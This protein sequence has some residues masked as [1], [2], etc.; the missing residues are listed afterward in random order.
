MW[1][2]AP[3]PSPS[4]IPGNCSRGCHEY[5]PSK[6]QREKPHRNLEVREKQVGEAGRVKLGGVRGGR[7]PVRA[8]GPPD[9]TRAANPHY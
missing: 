8:G 4:D 1:T 3:A 5:K 2:V 7:C 9:K 6:L